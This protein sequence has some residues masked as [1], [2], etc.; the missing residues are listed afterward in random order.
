MSKE[1]KKRRHRILD[2]PVLSVI[3]LILFVLFISFEG[4]L[5]G[6]IGTGLRLGAPVLFLDLAIFIFDRI[7]GRGAL[8]NVLMVL[9]ISLVAGIVEEITF[10]ASLRCASV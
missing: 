2:R 7:T 10:R 1:V 9:S 8:N 6:E 5:R 3:L 4:T